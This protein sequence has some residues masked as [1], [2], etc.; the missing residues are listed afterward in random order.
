MEKVV[1]DQVPSD[2]STAALSNLS[3][4]EREKKRG[5]TVF[6]MS[7][8]DEFDSFFLLLLLWITNNVLHLE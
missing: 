1:Q 3:N 2:M 5:S 7:D 8:Q 4:L 6:S